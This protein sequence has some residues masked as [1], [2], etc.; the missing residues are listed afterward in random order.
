MYGLKQAAILA[1][2]QLVENLKPF[3]YAP[4]EGTTGLWTHKTRPTKF[5]LCVDDF[6]VKFFS[7]EDAL[8]LISSLKKNY[9]ISQD[10]SGTNYCGLQIKWNYRKGFV[11]ISMPKYVQ[12]ALA[13]YQHKPPSKPQYAP[14]KYNEPVYGRKVQYAPIPEVSPVLP[15]KQTQ[16]VQSKIGTCLYYARGVEPTILVALNEL[17]TEQAKPTASTKKSLV[18]L[19]DYLWTYPNAVI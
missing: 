19:F 3:G 18:M 7:K 16:Q 9:E 15:S 13:K 11:D 17:G 12:N 4:I 10:W 8:H 1:Y 5:A 2:Q 14:Y 6:G